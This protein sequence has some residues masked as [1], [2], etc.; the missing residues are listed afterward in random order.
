MSTLPAARCT[1]TRSPL[2][3]VPHVTTL[4]MECNRVSFS[5]THFSRSSACAAHRLVYSP[6]YCYWQ[7]N[8]K[9]CVIPRFLFRG[10]PPPTHQHQQTQSKRPGEQWSQTRSPRHIIIGWL[11]QNDLTA[12]AHQRQNHA[13][14]QEVGTYKLGAGEKR[15]YEN[16]RIHHSQLSEHRT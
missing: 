8:S 2:H 12:R 16:R 9:H 3:G 1:Q 5:A 10:V 7:H 15:T 4:H 14:R 13:N 11:K 6:T